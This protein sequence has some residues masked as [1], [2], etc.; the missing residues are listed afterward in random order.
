MS[1]GSEVPEVGRLDL[2]P[3]ITDHLPLADAV[4]RLENKKFHQDHLRQG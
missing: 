4:N 3:T 2:A 1:R